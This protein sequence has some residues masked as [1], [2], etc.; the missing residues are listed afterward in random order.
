M[1]GFSIALAI[2]LLTFALVGCHVKENANSF[3]NVMAKRGY[4]K[5][6][7]QKL[8]TGHD[9][10]NAK[11]NGVDGLFIVD[12]GAITAFSQSLKA[13]F[14]FANAERLRTL[15]AAGAGGPISID[16][17]STSSFAVGDRV[18]PVQQIGS[19][20]LN[21]VRR[22]IYNATGR[23]VDGLIG[24]DILM[25]NQAVIDVKHQHLYLKQPS[26][27]TKPINHAQINWVV[28]DLDAI[29]LQKFDAEFLTVFIKIN[30]IEGRLLVDSG[31]VNSLLDN[32]SKPKFKLEEKTLIS[33]SSNTGAGGRFRLERH[34]LRSFDINNKAVN[35][36]TV[37][38][39][40]LS[41]VIA[42]VQLHTQTSI[43]GV[44]GQDVL[45]AHGAVI[46]VRAQKLYFRY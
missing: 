39:G 4:E 40:D 10:V 6:Q 29:R 38:V 31:A 22:G 18:I 16:Y 43:D 5:V 8:S 1:K 21:D 28:L 41:S 2:S 9:T 11:I 44:L 42:F 32:S 27:N 25:V 37:S 36:S 14:G 30:G 13:K 46:D 12:T 17:Y 45:I 24:Q 35:T 34:Q 20:N 19:T 23:Y 15:E 3:S 26:Q 33:R 7:L